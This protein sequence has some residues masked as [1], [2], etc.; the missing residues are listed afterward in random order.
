MTSASKIS[1]DQE[2]YDLVIV[3]A[4][5]AGMAAAA[6]GAR[7][8]LKVLLL[9]ASSYVGGTSA[10][11]AGSVWVPNS[12]LASDD[13]PNAARHYLD[14][15]VGNWSRAEM[16]AAF[17]ARGPEM[18]A[19]LQAAG[20]VDLAPYPYHPDYLA[21]LPGAVTRGRALGA[22]AFDGRSLGR[23]FGLLRPP[24]PEFTI[25]GGMM[26]DRNDI[27][28]LLSAGRKPA[29]FLH[30]VKLV[31]RHGWDRLFAPRGRRLVMGNALAGRLLAYLLSKGVTI[32]ARETVSEIIMENDRAVG[33]VANGERIEAR[34][35]VVV[36]TGG[37]SHHATLRDELYPQPVAQYSAVPA[38][39]SG[40]GVDLLQQA[41][42]HI[43]SDHAN[44][45]FWAPASVRRR[46]DGSLAIFPHFVLDRAKPGI[47][48]VDAAGRRF[49]DEST[50]YQRFVEGMYQANAVPCH[51]VCNGDFVRRYGFGVIRPMTRNLQPWVEEGYLRTGRTIEE[52]ARAI[53]A[54]ADV[55]ADSFARNDRYAAHGEDPEFGRG[56]TSYARNLGDP[57]HGPN[58]C[59]GP[60]GEGPYYALEIHPADIG[61]SMGIATDTE[62]RVLDAGGE[63]IEGLYAAGNDMA[64]VMGG[65]YPGPGITLG[66]ALTFGYV[67]AKH[68]ASRRER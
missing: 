40:G 1:N 13:D 6:T 56:E 51:L 10:L 62:A 48:A 5:A 55:L 9:E 52:L 50:S 34:C 23:N 43:D 47:I 2:A 21:D 63:P 53:G 31:M 35:G 68:A 67:A 38:S 64:S 29:S 12:P 24:L 65:T 4:G 28:H 42:G 22:K 37:F 16:R 54:E 27:N 45:A 41:G 33:V 32:R 66:P 30:A 57:G 7:F 26:V 36:S 46:T 11:S 49:V 3:G 19:E 59:L 61:T 18:I 8:G 15:V 39:N 44:A 17:L 14:N 20:A 25:F 60:M 58:P